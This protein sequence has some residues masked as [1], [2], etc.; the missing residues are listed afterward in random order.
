MSP[1]IGEPNLVPPSLPLVIFP[2]LVSSTCGQNVTL[3]SSGVGT[4]IIS[5][6][7]FNGSVSITTEVFKNGV[8]IGSSFPLIISPFGDDDFGNYAFVAST[9]KCGSTSALSWILPG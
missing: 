2:F 4:L 5:C 9:R 6:E 7:I 3:P 1:F 8:S